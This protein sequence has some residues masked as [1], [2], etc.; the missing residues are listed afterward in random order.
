MV[1][2]VVVYDVST[3]ARLFTLQAVGYDDY[4]K[5][6]LEG[7]GEEQ[8]G[9]QVARHTHPTGRQGDPGLTFVGVAR[10]VR[11]C[12]AGLVVFFFAGG[13]DAAEAVRVTG[14]RLAAREDL[15]PTG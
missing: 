5:K 7:A 1:R 10:A 3:G 13:G 11:V 15:L 9:E 6:M 14:G 12:V 4:T 2:V 8:G